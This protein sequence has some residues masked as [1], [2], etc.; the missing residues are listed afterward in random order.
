MN[1]NTIIELINKKVIETKELDNLLKLNDEEVK[2]LLS[3]KNTKT[4]AFIKNYLFSLDTNQGKNKKI[5]EMISGIKNEELI[6]YFVKFVNFINDKRLLDIIYNKV[7]LIDSKEKIDALKLVV[8]SLLSTNQNI[9]DIINNILFSNIDVLRLYITVLTDEN[10]K[11]L[12]NYLDVIEKILKV[13]DLNRLI[14]LVEL[15]TDDESLL[16]S[17]YFSYVVL[18]ALEINDSFRLT[19]M[20]SIFWDNDLL[21]LSNYKSIIDKVMEINS[22]EHLKLIINIFGSEDIWGVDNNIENIVTIIQTLNPKLI[23]A[24]KECALDENLINNSNYISSLKLLS[25]MRNPFLS[26]LFVSVLTNTNLIESNDYRF[27][28]ELASTIENRYTFYTFVDLIENESFVDSIFITAVLKMIVQNQNR[29][30]SNNF[31]DIL[32]NPYF[33]I[34]SNVYLECI[35]SL[36]NT[37]DESKILLLSNFIENEVQYDLSGMNDFLEFIFNLDDV[38]LIKEF[39]NLICDE[40]IKYSDVLDNILNK[41]YSIE[42]YEILRMYKDLVKYMINENR[43]PYE[44]EVTNSFISWLPIK[45]KKENVSDFNYILDYATSIK[46]ISRFKGLAQIVTDEDLANTRTDDNSL[47]FILDRMKNVTLENIPYFVNIVLNS[48][49]INL[50]NYKEVVET[51]SMINETEKLKVIGEIIDTESG[52]ILIEEDLISRNIFNKDIRLLKDLSLLFN[53]FSYS[54]SIF[55]SYEFKVF[56]INFIDNYD[57][58]NSITVKNLIRSNNEIVIK[59]RKLIYTALSKIANNYADLNYLSVLLTKNGVNR[60]D[61]ET[62]K[63]ELFGKSIMYDQIS[64]EDLVKVGTKDEI[65]DTLMRMDDNEDVKANTLVR[66]LI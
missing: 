5:I 63:L 11:K 55:T 31:F 3:I 18:K 25:D 15:I 44:E 54:S 20:C 24:F 51:L 57:N 10:L 23:N 46:D 42:N 41:A 29:F 56:V 30:Y 49:I 33:L 22:I 13:Q 1:R 9:I 65:I 2:F 36:F 7:E 34:N 26:D 62:I 43:F 19:L 12:G 64:F 39:I 59:Y 60:N 28:S 6:P 52:N 50:D 8:N 61:I 53:Q 17:D 38:N 47:Q 14:P 4:L 40:D 66:K 58:E 16:E 37:Y 48:G 21:K 27:V 35:S 32:V 45:K